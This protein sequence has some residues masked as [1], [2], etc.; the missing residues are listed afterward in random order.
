MLSLYSIE[1]FSPVPRFSKS[2]SP[3][4]KIP[5]KVQ[6]FVQRHRKYKMTVLS[7]PCQNSES[8]N[9]S[10]KPSTSL[11]FHMSP[12]YSPTLYLQNS[13]FIISTQIKSERKMTST[14]NWK[15]TNHNPSLNSAIAVT[16]YWNKESNNHITTNQFQKLNN[17]D[18]E[19]NNKLKSPNQSPPPHPPEPKPSHHDHHHHAQTHHISYHY[20]NY[21][22][23]PR[24]AI[25]I[26]PPKLDQQSQ[27]SPPKPVFTTTTTATITKQSH[28]KTN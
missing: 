23:N 3:L 5:K 24:C 20:H 9:L 25:T 27:S 12:L 16:H 7:I 6:P 10:L 22:Q 15:Q 11:Q 8:N 14:Q 4:P 13:I 1:I 17:C 2:S 26:T 21:H 18:L 28:G 19:S